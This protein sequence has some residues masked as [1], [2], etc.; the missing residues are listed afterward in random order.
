MFVSMRAY[1]RHRGVSL[2]AVQKAIRSGRIDL[3]PGGIDTAQADL[4]WARNTGTRSRQFRVGDKQ[5]RQPPLAYLS[6]EGEDRLHGVL[7]AA[8][9]LDGHLAQLAQL[10]IGERERRLVSREKVE[11]S[12][13]EMAHHT[14]H[15]LANESN[16]ANVETILVNQIRAAL[17][18]VT[19]A[20]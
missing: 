18:T 3:E 17:R 14:A 8:A 4:E 10:E 20:V 19:T 11:A 6:N 1:A 15:V 2:A 13:L 5:S 9:R 12:M 16:S 7:E